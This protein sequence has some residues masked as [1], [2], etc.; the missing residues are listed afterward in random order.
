MPRGTR[1]S[2]AGYDKLEPLKQGAL[3][4]LCSIYSIINAATL[5]AYPIQPLTK[6]QQRRLFEAG[7]H[8]LGGSKL[9]GV[10]IA[11]MNERAW[12]RLRDQL[13][14]ELIEI[15]GP[16]IRHHAVGAAAAQ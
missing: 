13:Y 10:A 15:G 16:R 1:I 3:D 11:G 8:Q 12:M 9:A 14:A 5:A 6:L 2:V 7:V 4:G